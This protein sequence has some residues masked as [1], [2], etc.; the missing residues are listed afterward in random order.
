MIPGDVLQRNFD[1]LA[2]NRHGGGVQDVLRQL[3]EDG[4]KD[5]GP[6]I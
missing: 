4:V 3:L 2:A 1:R 5:L 6:M